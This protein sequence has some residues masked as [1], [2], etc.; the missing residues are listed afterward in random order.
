MNE[1]SKP[2]YPK[3]SNEQ[4]SY[5]EELPGWTWDRRKEV[6]NANF[7]ILNN[8]LQIDSFKSITPLTVH[9]NFSLGRW[10]VKQRQAFKE[11]KLESWKKELLESLNWVADPFE[12]QWNETFQ[13]LEKY[14]TETGTAYVPQN[15][16]YMEKRLGAWVS[17]QRQDFKIKKLSL[18]RIEKLQKL[19]G[20]S[21]DA[22]DKAAHSI[23]KKGLSP[24]K[25]R[26]SKS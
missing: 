12:T 15:L 7:L 13:I 22:T 16:T 2:I 6:W 21:W 9:Q 4:I 20:W 26:R 23:S 18:E 8:F 24:S 3:L 5:L 19:H 14:L 17:S 25:V 1:D 11:G 10:I